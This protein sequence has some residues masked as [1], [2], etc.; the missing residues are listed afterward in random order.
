[1]GYFCSAVLNGSRGRTSGL[2]ERQYLGVCMR[3]GKGRERK[4]GEE[5]GGEDVK[6]YSQLLWYGTYLK[7]AEGGE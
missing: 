2:S 1:M 4:Q 7:L 5:K 3:E 6:R